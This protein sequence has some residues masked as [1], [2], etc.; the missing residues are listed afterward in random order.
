[1]S[2]GEK[3]KVLLQLHVQVI[4]LLQLASDSGI[5]MQLWTWEKVQTGIMQDVS[6]S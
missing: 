6:L 2:N 1:M 4:K 3:G 5:W